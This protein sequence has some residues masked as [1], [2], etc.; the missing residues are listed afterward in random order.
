MIVALIGGEIALQERM[1]LAVRPGE[2]ERGINLHAKSG[3]QFTIF[4]AVDFQ[5]NEISFDECRE[6][7]I[8]ERR[9][10]HLPAV[11]AF[12]RLHIDEQGQVLLRRFLAGLIVIRP[13]FDRFG[14][15]WRKSRRRTH[16]V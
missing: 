14:S 11:Q 2:H 6:G 3:G 13:P 12:G 10:F 4:I 7:R 8:D 1:N 9:R 15:R 5:R 16:R